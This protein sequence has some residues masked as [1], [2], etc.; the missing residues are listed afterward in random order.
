MQIVEDSSGTRYLLLKESTSSSLVRDLETG[1]ERYLDSDD[2][3][4]VTSEEPLSVVAGGLP[5]HVRR[6]VTAVHD[7]RALGLVMTLV[8]RGPTD[9]RT[10]LA[11][12]TFCE[13]DLHGLLA[14]LRAAGLLTETRI[15]GIRGYE[16]TADARRAVTALRG[17]RDEKD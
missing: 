9:V 6:L 12:T 1:E 15:G 17:E 4:T 8:D 14:E 2:L 10:L 13:S 16:P 11:E 5:E 3:S 7:D